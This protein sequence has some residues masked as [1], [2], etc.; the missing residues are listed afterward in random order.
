[1]KP[2]TWNMHIMKNTLTAGGLVLT[3][4][5]PLSDPWTYSLVIATSHSI[6]EWK[7]QSGLGILQ[8]QLHPNEWNE[9]VLSCLVSFC[10]FLFD[11]L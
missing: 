9:F 5:G 1:M 2:M 8:L 10:D 4:V 3:T 11:I 6:V 7:G